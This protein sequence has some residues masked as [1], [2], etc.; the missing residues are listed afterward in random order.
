MVFAATGT[1][2]DVWKIEAKAVHQL[3]EDWARLEADFDDG[4]DS[5]VYE[6]SARIAQRLRM[7]MERIA[8]AR[9]VRNRCAHLD[10]KLTEREIAQSRSVLDEALIR[11]L[12]VD[13]VDQRRIADEAVWEQQRRAGRQERHD[14]LVKYTTLLNDARDFDDIA[15]PAS[16][17][18]ARSDFRLCRKVRDQVSHP[19]PPPLATD[20]T[21]A[22]R[23]VTAVETA[24]HELEEARTVEAAEE[25]AAKLWAEQVARR[26]AERHE[27]AKETRA[28]AES[29]SSM[30]QVGSGTSAAHLAGG[31][32]P[33][34]SWQVNSVTAECSYCGRVTKVIGAG[35]HYVCI[36]GAV[37]DREESGPNNKPRVTSQVAP[38]SPADSGSTQRTALSS[39]DSSGSGALL[40]VIAVGVALLF[41][42]PL[43]GF[44]L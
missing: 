32:T 44:L 24:L 1:M 15:S 26:L 5:D 14:Y 33:S 13:V 30:W 9:R 25:H 10:P 3:L 42:W 41:L 4:P 37:V 31:S 17:H 19:S 40:L 7:S 39:D 28:A 8:D 16:Q 35:R 43:V 2:R 36:C 18:L 11:Y 34:H 12:S 22:M 27:A 29:P 6:V 38:P 20:L 23:I 21:A